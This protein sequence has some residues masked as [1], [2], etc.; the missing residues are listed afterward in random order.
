MTT[1]LDDGWKGSNIGA[2]FALRGWRVVSLGSTQWVWCGRGTRWLMSLPEHVPPQARPDELAALLRHHNMIALRYPSLAEAGL[3]GGLYICRDRSYSMQNVA[4]GFRSA[5]KGGLARCE[6]R[7]VTP[8]E[9]LSEGI[10]CNRD[11]MLRQ[12]RE[13]TEFSD[14]LRWS[15]FVD[16]A[17]RIPALEVTGAFVD[18]CLAAYQ[19]GCLDAGCWNIAYAFSRTAL[20]EHRPNH[21]LMFTA[22]EKQLRRPGVEAVCAGPK[23]VLVEDGL[24]DFK[25]RMGFDLE[26]HQVVVRFHPAIEGML[27]SEPVVRS[28]Q[29]L[30]GMLPQSLRL[31]RAGA[32]LRAARA[33]RREETQVS[34]LAQG[35]LGLTGSS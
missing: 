29:F 16:S 3:P 30:R 10:E 23:T 15:R 31:A 12:G 6:I 27:A 34:L 11:T 21:A 17:W 26:P 28:V 32:F 19:L 2:F 25:T 7:P 20:L 13:N 14:P 8:D 5:V 24:H 22:L 35:P 18:G 33:A 9:M 1:E 4:R